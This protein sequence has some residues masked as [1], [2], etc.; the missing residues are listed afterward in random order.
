MPNELTS[1]GE[2]KAMDWISWDHTLMTGHARMDADHKVLAELF[3]LLPHA[4]EQRKGKDFCAKVLDDIIQH[5]TSHF[6]LERQLMAQY[7][8]PKTK[9]HM[10]E[11]AMLLEQ[12]LHY[13]ATFD[14]DS[15]E[16]RIALARFPEV[17]LGFHI[18]FSDKDLANF[19]AQAA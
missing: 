13:E 8:Y 17:W 16:S 19:L 15:S 12:A 7:R 10:A 9:Q 11:H 14:M 3:N 6:D 2:P 18:L 4:V 5:A 1:A